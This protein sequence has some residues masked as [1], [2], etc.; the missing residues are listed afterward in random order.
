M[1]NKQQDE[2]S[3]LRP[4]IKPS[5]KRYFILFMFVLLIGLKSFQ[6]I[7]FASIT[8]VIAEF[9]Q[10][11][12]VMVNWTTV[13]FMITYLTLALPISCLNE[14]LGLR[15]GLIIGAIGTSVGLI[16]KC[17]SCSRDGFTVAFIGHVVIGLVEPF[18]Y[19][20]YSQLAI[21]WFP[22]DQVSMATSIG[23]MGNTFGMAIAFIVPVS[24]VGED[25]SDL[26]RV[27]S[28]LFYLF[29]V[30]AVLC[31]IDT[32]L[33][34]LFFDEQPK[35]AP[36][37]ARHKQIEQQRLAKALQQDSSHLQGAKDFLEILGELLSSR[38]FN[39]MHISFGVNIGTGYAIHTVLN[40]VIAGSDEQLHYATSVVGRAGLILLLMGVVGSVVCGFILDKWHAYKTT[41]FLLYLLAIGSLAGFTVCL[42]YNEPM[43]VYVTVGALGL[44]LT[45]YECCGFEYAVELTYPKPEQ[46]SATMLN[47]SGQIYGILVTFAA[48]II[49]DTYGSTAG[50]CFLCLSLAL[51]SITSLATGSNYKRLRSLTEEPGRKT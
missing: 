20:A 29:L 31:C 18:F 27:Q 2:R 38:D 17:Y 46:I 39:L 21:V 4:A 24:V 35:C 11:S 28:G 47:V 45:G 49:V 22:D 44:C 41:A 36:G 9:Y 26:E 51:G 23:V 14:R 37:Q 32:I 1:A 19:S 33:I 25:A 15:N 42:K 7:F 8:N 48:S 13:V 3:P 30:N 40:Q 34:V 5:P 10:V 6:W 50:C 43:L 16:I 12:N